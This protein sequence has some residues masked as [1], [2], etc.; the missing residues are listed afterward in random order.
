MDGTSKIVWL[1]TFLLIFSA[2]DQNGVMTMTSLPTAAIPSDP[3]NPE[4]P[5][6]EPIDSSQAIGFYSDGRLLDGV[7]L[8]NESFAHLKIFRLR[9][10][11]HATA[12]LVNTILNASKIFREKFPSGDRVQIGDMSSELGGQLS[13]HTSHQN[14]LDADIAYL[15]TNHRERNPDVWGN[16]GFGEVFVSGG[17]VTANFDTIRNWHLL[18]EMIL[19]KN[20]ARIFV[21]PNIKR[22]FC[23]VNKTIDPKASLEVRTEVLRR[24]RPYA[25]H[26]DHFHMRI[27]CPL[28]DG[29]CISQEAPPTGSGC[30]AIEMAS[31]DE[32]EL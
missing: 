18:K 12:S 3:V 5:V 9:Y 30:S 13:R 24:L 27:D 15:Q 2:C 17:K 29:R 11:A 28:R 26:D 25:N 4:T 7:Q 6:D 23:D 20:V 16:S 21:D 19:Q 31:F 1:T 14:G 8:P 32:H 10:R 22:T